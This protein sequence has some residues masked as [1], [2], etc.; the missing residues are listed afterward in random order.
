MDYLYGK[1]FDQGH[2]NNLNQTKQIASRKPHHFDSHL[3]WTKSLY[4]IGVSQYIV[5]ADQ[6]LTESFIVWTL[7]MYR[8]NIK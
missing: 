3:G 8:V 7:W 4:W 5:S 6:M 2:Q 1:L